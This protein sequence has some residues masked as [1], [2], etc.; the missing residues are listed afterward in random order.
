MTGPIVIDAAQWQEFARLIAWIAFFSGVAG[1][2]LFDFL[3]SAWH[4]LQRKL[5]RRRGCDDFADSVEAVVRKMDRSR[6]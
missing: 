2:V 4:W 6:G 1:A 3:R 5:D